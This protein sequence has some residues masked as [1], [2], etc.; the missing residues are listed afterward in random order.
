MQSSYYSRELFYEFMKRARV[1]LL[2][3]LAKKFFKLS[4]FNYQKICMPMDLHS[5]HDCDCLPVDT[6]CK[7]LRS[8][9]KL[10]QVILSRNRH[11]IKVFT[12][13]GETI[14]YA[15]DIED[16]YNNAYS[17]TKKD[18]LGYIIFDGYLWLLGTTTAGVVII[19]AIFAD[20][21][22][23]AN[24]SFCTTEGE[25]LDYACYDASTDDFPLQASLDIAM[26]QEVANIMQIPLQIKEDLI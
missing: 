11:I 16:F 19:N 14:D 5:F 23:L 3:R 8:R 24:I 12:I 4:D 25:E 2:E 22:E 18:K 6:K 7:L 10:P 20:P 9:F 13:T 26:Y 21:V 15:Q 17:V 1:L